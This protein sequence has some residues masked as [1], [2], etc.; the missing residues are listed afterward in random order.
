MM[1]FEYWVDKFDPVPSPEPAGQ[2]FSSY[3]LRT[4][5]PLLLTE[6]LKTRLCQHGEVAQSADD[7]TPHP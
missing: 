7:A 2:G 3:V 1:H 6:A 5:Q 4:G